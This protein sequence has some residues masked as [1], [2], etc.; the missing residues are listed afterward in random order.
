MTTPPDL[1]TF[2]LGDMSLGER[3]AFARAT[4]YSIESLADDNI[5]GPERE[6]MLVHLVI[7][8]GRRVD[9][10]FS[11]ADAERVTVGQLTELTEG[12]TAASDPK[13]QPGG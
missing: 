2:S 5:P 4:G 6:E 8:A 1:G 7:M 11:E 13:D 3:R 9:P 12:A 10:T